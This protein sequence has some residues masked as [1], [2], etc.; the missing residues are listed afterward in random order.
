MRVANELQVLDAFKLVDSTDDKGAIW[1]TQ[2]HV[3]STQY[4]ESPESRRKIWHKGEDSWLGYRGRWG[5]K[6]NNDCWWF[7]LVGVC[8]VC[9]G[10]PGEGQKTKKV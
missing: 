10:I 3:V 6:G 8:Q 2:N 1:D 4:W 7:K 9:C 5:N